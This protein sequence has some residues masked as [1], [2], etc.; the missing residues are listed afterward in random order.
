MRGVAERGRKLRDREVGLGRIR[1]S[2]KQSRCSCSSR[3]CRRRGDSRGSRSRETGANVVRRR[4]LGDHVRRAPSR[5]R[6]WCAK[7]VVAGE[8]SVGG[9]TDHDVRLDVE[10]SPLREL[11]VV[12]RGVVDHR[13][14]QSLIVAG[15]VS[16]LELDLAAVDVPARVVGVLVLCGLMTVWVFW[17]KPRYWPFTSLNTLGCNSE[18]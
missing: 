15:R 12:L 17:S 6:T 4:R 3:N 14:R 16:A 11:S 2:S 13:L 8:N 18:W 5:Y 7:G 9:V 10:R 1:A